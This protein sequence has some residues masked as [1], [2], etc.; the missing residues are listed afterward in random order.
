MHKRLFTSIA[1]GAVLA[2]GSTMAGPAQAS[3]CASPLALNTATGASTPA[4]GP[5]PSNSVLA[6][7][8][9][10]HPFPACSVPQE[11]ADTRRML[12]G[13][14]HVAPSYIGDFGAG[15]PR[16]TAY[17]SG[18]GFNNTAVTLTRTVITGGAIYASGWSAVPTGPTT[19]SAVISVRL[20]NPANGATLATGT[21]RSTT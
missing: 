19:I 3:H 4:A 1:A 15:I 11:Q 6:T 7:H 8:P 20:V 12:P 10:I 14:T 21:W 9:S 18:A 17:L 2:A 13:T 16:V 5:E